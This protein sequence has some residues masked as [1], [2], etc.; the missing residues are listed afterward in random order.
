M[1]RTQLADCL[2]FGHP[3]P[4]LLYCPAYLVFI[5]I[6]NSDSLVTGTNYDVYYSF[7]T[8]NVYPNHTS[9]GL[10]LAGY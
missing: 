4:Y 10:V 1:F 7:A 3:R 8:P 2:N 9:M 5:D 6:D